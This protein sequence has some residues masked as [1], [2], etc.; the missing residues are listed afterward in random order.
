MT[1]RIA[2]LATSFNRRELTLS[3]L[4]SLFAQCG[5]D[6]LNLTVFLLDDCSSDGTADAVAA[7]FPMVRLLRGDG[8]LFWNG[9]MRV[10]FQAAMREDFDAFLWFN[11]DSIFCPDALAR[12]VACSNEQIARGN[13]AI[14]T[15]SL[16]SPSTGT[17]TYGGWKKRPS[18]LHLHFE[19]VTPDQ[20]RPIP[21][22]TTNGNFVLIPK[23][24]VAVLGNLEPTFTHRFG[25]LDYGLRAQRAGFSVIVAPGFH[26]SCSGNT[27][28][29]T[30]RD[31]RMSRKERW[32]HLI[33][34]KGVPWREW[35][36]FTQRH[37]GWRWPIYAS[38]PYV[39]VLLGGLYKRNV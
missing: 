39:K 4:R 16:R 19:R 30:W 12:L 23:E 11:D 38:S 36:L 26:G 10:A 29:R 34:P 2:A 17:L 37:F 21:C 5:I 28:E 8:K 14:V 3:S 15:G 13:P 31:L 22:H 25:D 27:S 18:G 32:R 33:S 6:H 9:A 24:I 35:L 20:V 7:Q 1:Q